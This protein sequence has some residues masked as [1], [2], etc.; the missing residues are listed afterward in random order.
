VTKPLGT[1]ANSETAD[2][3]IAVPKGFVT[4]GSS[5]NQ[6]SFSD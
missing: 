1:A 3:I 2:L 6:T 5:S 4:V